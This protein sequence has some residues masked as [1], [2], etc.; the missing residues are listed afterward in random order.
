MDAGLIERIESG[1]EAGA[2]ALFAA[3]A[4]YAA[5]GL[6]TV[7]G[8][9]PQLALGAA[10][11]GLLAYLPCSWALGLAAGRK[12][13]FVL[14]T[15]TPRDFEF[16]EA[17]EELLLTERVSSTDELLL[18]DRVTQNDELILTDKDRLDSNSPLVLD[19]IAAQVGPNSRVVRL[20]DP[21]AMPAATPG[22]LQSRIAGH[23]G[24]GASSR[25]PSDASQALS[26]ALAELRRSLR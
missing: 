11:A 14:A 9:Q 22:E 1:A 5:Y 17:V 13:P 23:L 16:S 2:A 18:T 19:D 4:S 26:A 7:A 6:A 8:V 21:K 15:Y 20:F 10:A 3:A 12:R 25:A 24:D